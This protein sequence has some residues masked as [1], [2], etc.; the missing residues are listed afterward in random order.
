V[1]RSALTC[2]WCT[3]LATGTVTASDGRR[4][5]VAPVPHCDEHWDTAYS[6]VRRYPERTWKHLEQPEGLF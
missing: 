6:E 5:V 1:K 4:Q 2:R 3:A